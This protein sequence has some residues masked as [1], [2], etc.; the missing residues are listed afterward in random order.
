MIEAETVVLAR[1]NPD[2]PFSYVPV[3]ALKGVAA[4]EPIPFLV[5]STMRRRLAAD[6][7]AAVLF[8]RE[9]D[10]WVQ[11]A[12]VNAPVR[13]MVDD[14]L[15]AAPAWAVDP[16]QGERFAFFAELHDHPSD[17]IRLLALAEISR[18]PYTQIRGMTPRLSRAAIARTLRDPKWVEWA[19]IHIL[20]LGLSDDPDDHAFVRRM[21]RLAATRGIRSN[22]GAWATA[23]VEI[24]GAA[25][26]DW[27]RQT[28]FEDPDRKLEELREVVTAFDVIG[29]SGDPELRPTLVAA[30]RGLARDRPE[31]AADAA[32]QLATLGDW[33]QVETFEALIDSGKIDSP[34]ADFV[35]AQYLRSAQAA[36]A[37]TG[38]ERPK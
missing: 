4:E 26:L 13:A 18:A 10:R 25:G 22:T 1:E 19:P 38:P 28:Y 37:A 11:L 7:D 6:G 24:D 16:D 14:I 27:L 36:L 29:Q 31:L 3:E 9:A 30:L 5:D 15:A 20:F 17:T 2:R 32:K 34:A 33:S 12:Y 8:I 21:T 35:I 23:L